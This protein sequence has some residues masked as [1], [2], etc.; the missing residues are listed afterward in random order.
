MKL[1]C[2]R[3]LQNHGFFDKT[4]GVIFDKVEGLTLDKVYEGSA[5]NDGS[6][7]DSCGFVIYNDD[8]KWQMYNAAF[9]IPASS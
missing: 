1:K 8:N 3:E 4:K 7:N 9:F 5:V 6:Y 2:I